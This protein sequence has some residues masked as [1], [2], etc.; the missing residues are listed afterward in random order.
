MRGEVLCYKFG[1]SE[2]LGKPGKCVVSDKPNFPVESF[3]ISS[4]GGLQCM[5][6][7]PSLIESETAVNVKVVPTPRLLYSFNVPTLNIPPD[8]SRENNVQVPTGFPLT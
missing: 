4:F 7:F 8:L 5:K 3:C 6:P 2:F 1:A